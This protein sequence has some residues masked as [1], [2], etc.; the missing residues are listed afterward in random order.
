[1]HSSSTLFIKEKAI[2]SII[3]LMAIFV[4]TPREVID[5]VIIFGHAH[6]AL[7]YLYQYKAGKIKTAYILPYLLTLGISFYIAFEYKDY[8]IVFVAIAF[9]F[10]NFFDEFKLQNKSPTREHYALI[11]MIIS[12]LAGWIIKDFLGYNITRPLIYT[13]FI[14]AVA[15]FFLHKTNKNLTYKCP[16]LGY[17]TLLTGTFLV[18]E[19]TNN[20]PNT[21]DSFG[22]I[23]LTHYLAWYIRLGVQFKKTE[24]ETKN[25]KTYIQ[26]VVLINTIFIAGY[27][28]LKHPAIDLKIIH[29][30]FYEPIG[31]YVWT[32]M[33]LI[34]TL[35]LTNKKRVVAL[36]SL[37]KF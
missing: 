20:Q 33:H 28:I 30:T 14:L 21:S 27:F 31:F 23:I 15:T 7:T 35:R 1:M 36:S 4:L 26:Q 18:M 8:F 10:H 37:G 5:L 22:F 29:H 11:F 32:M 12:L 19:F 2:S 34:T 13:I 16:Y 24:T 6:F 17:L 9:L 25:Y 3:A